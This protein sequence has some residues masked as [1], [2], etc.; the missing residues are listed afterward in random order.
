MKVDINEI[1]NYLN[2]KANI[3]QVN[4]AISMINKEID[5]KLDNEIFLSNIKKQEEINK[6]LC[7]ENIIGK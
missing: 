3:D 2:Q 6:I 1:K 7:N 5:N 4:K